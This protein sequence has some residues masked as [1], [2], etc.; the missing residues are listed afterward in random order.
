MLELAFRQSTPAA[1]Q[2]LVR[3]GAGRQE[4][5]EWVAKQTEEANTLFVSK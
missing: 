2:R 3:R 1:R 5:K 4:T